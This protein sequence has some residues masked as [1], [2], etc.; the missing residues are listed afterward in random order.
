MKALVK[1]DICDRIKSDI[2]LSISARVA[3]KLNTSQED[4]ALAEYLLDRGADPNYKGYILELD[5]AR[6]YWLVASP[7]C[8]FLAEII[9][10]SSNS[11]T[12]LSIQG[13]CHVMDSFLSHGANTSDLV[14]LN[15]RILDFEEVK[16]IPLDE[17]MYKMAEKDEEEEEVGSEF[18]VLLVPAFTLIDTLV[19]QLEETICKT[20][21]SQEKCCNLEHVTSIRSKLKLIDT[22][23]KPRIITLVSN[24][25]S[26]VVSDKDSVYLSNTVGKLLTSPRPQDVT[27][28]LRD[29]YLEVYRR[30][31]T[32][33]NLT[34]LLEDEG[35][36][37]VHEAHSHRP[38]E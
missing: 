12:E 38:D 25:A 36:I 31:A 7:F 15:I 24:T 13:V 26:R 34:A 22:T 29:R 19:S 3:S 35:L 20:G 9:Q 32:R 4:I 1:R 14:N 27:A 23:T 30:S 5:M 10:T 28:M 37:W 8:E 2:L 33:S 16:F 18:C 6:R 17:I 11:S 21:H